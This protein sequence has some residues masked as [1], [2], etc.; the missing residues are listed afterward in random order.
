M[1][2]AVLLKRVDHAVLGARAGTST[3]IGANRASSA[4]AFSQRVSKAMRRELLL[5][6]L[7][8]WIP[9]ADGSDGA[10]REESRT[11]QAPALGA[12]E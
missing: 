5:A 11:A 6:P 10:Q 7:R 3:G 1:R 9:Q 12:R 4:V 8:R 2:F